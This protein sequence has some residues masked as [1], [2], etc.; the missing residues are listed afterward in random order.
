M[1][2][3]K[4]LRVTNFTDP[5]MGLSYESRSSAS[6]RLISQVASNSGIV[7]PDWCGTFM[8]SLILLI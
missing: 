6:S 3:E 5:M 8:I 7:C 2:H 1:T 4:M